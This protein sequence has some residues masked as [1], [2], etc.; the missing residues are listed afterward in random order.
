MSSTPEGGRPGRSDLRYPRHRRR[1]RPGPHRSLLG[2][3]GHDAVLGPE[4]FSPNDMAATM[5]DVLG[6]PVRYQQQVASDSFEAQLR[7]QGMSDAFVRGFVEM[8]RAKAEGLD[9]A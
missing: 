3:L 6:K 2:R 8:M 5:S 4:N 7:G 9:T 1:R